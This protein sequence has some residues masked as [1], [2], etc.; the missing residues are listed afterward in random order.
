M[1]IKSISLT[2]INILVKLTVF[3][4]FLA[5]VAF[6][7]LLKQQFI[8]GP[9][10]NAVLFISTVYLGTL[11]GVLISF[12]PSLF[13]VSIGLLPVPLLPMIPYIIMS[14]IILV[15]FFGAFRKKSFWLAAISAS[16]L[17]FLFLFLSGSFIINF[18]IKET[19]SAKIAVMMSWPQL[20]TALVGSLIAFLVL[21]ISKENS[22]ND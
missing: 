18:F 16:F 5:V 11:A 15:L 3:T 21:K 12:L 8:T 19:L 10:V 7:P 17:K 4:V 13:A 20:I 22:F 9:I 6:A 2:Q 14:N 1:K